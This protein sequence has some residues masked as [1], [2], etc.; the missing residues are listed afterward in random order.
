MCG[1]FV[2][3]SDPDGL[4]RFFVIDERKTDDLP[5]SYNV[6]PTDPVYAVAAHHER[7]YLVS[8]RWGLVPHWAESPATGAKMINA[9]AETAAE[10]P[11][12]RD[13]LR[14]RRCLIPADGFY[15]WRKDAGGAKT[16]HFI[17][18]PDEQP[19]AFAGLWET[20]RDASDPQAPPLKT[21]TILTRPAVEHLQVLHDRMPVTLAPETWDD[22]LDPET[23]PPAVQLLLRTPPP[24]LTFRPVSDQ[25]N[26]VRNNGPQLLAAAG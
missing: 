25:V 17:H 5:P 15:E 16:P 13:A 20:W 24:P 11:A 8:F 22:W 10:K 9:R 21:C 18:R 6:A 3:A 4:V 2:S 26:S 19:I 12:Y 7:R 1:R 14:R 23:P